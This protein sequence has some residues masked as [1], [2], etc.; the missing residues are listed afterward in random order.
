MISTALVIVSAAMALQA[1]DTTRAARESFTHCLRVFVDAS[2]H[3]HKTLAQ[4]NTE[5]PQACPAEQ[6]A[7]RQAIIQ[8]DMASRSTRASAEESANLE[9]EDARANFNDIFQMSLPPDQV[10]HAAPAPATAAPSQP[11]VAA[12]PAAQTTGAAQP[13]AQPAAQP[14]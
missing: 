13:P 12:Q 11:T 10:A 7:F 6:T 3:A 5:Y 9:V 8:R 4:F 1:S 2:T 14:H